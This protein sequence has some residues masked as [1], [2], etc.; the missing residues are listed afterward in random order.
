MDKLEDL[1]LQILKRSKSENTVFRLGYL[2]YLC[3]WNAALFTGHTI[4]KKKYEYHFGTIKN[5]LM[6]S[7]GNSMYFKFLNEQNVYGSKKYIV[8]PSMDKDETNLTK[9]EI[10]L[11]NVVVDQVDQFY[12]ND[13]VDYVSSTKP[14]NEE[15]IYSILNLEKSAKEYF[16]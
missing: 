11:I 12:F 9:K 13:L 1:C 14:F 2:V 5:D 15:T 7:I 4:S 3:D 8:F 6:N 16:I 10:A